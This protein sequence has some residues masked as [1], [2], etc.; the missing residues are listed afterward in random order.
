MKNP[1]LSPAEIHA[2]IAQLQQRINDLAAQLPDTS[3]V[4][5]PHTQHNHLGEQR[6]QILLDTASIA[7]VVVDNYG[8]IL[9]ANQKASEIF[10]YTSDE[11]VNAPVSI[12]L[13]QHLRETHEEH[14]NR[15]F[16]HPRPRPM[17]QGMDL[18]AQRQNGTLFPIEVSL[19]AIQS[20]QGMQGVA[21][22]VDISER[23]RAEQQQLDLLAEQERVDALQ[24]FVVDVAHDLK[25]PMAAVM[26]RIHI[27][28]KLL[29]E[30]VA[31]HT[32]K[33][34]GHVDRLNHLV[35]TMLLMTQL[36]MIVQLELQTFDVNQLVHHAVDSSQA[37]LQNKHH[38]LTY[39][40][41]SSLPTI[42]V[43]LQHLMTAI[44]NI[45]TN[46][47]IFTPE[48]GQI[49]ITTG[50]TEH[51]II[52]AVQDNGMGIAET[53]LPHIF[54]RFYRA[55]RSRSMDESINGLGLAIAKRIVDLHH[56]EIV[57]ESEVGKGSTFR[58]LLPVA[59]Q[60]QPNDDT[61]L[62]HEIQRS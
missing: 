59:T 39:N 44:K 26:T 47:V 30:A 24:N 7:I 27:M 52:V 1:K 43:H 61:L 21:F 54:K 34:A 58:L 6:F 38:H 18:M 46:A 2:E 11:L 23:K 19:S 25:T 55:D 32:E 56:G 4:S 10:G 49:T 57:V 28:D 60:N 13:P 22:I 5:I 20:E 3:A 31:H 16:A 15:F 12:L 45:L 53:D 41:D 9:I 33:L 35:D 51:G 62:L 48:G 40:L 29:G 50:T 36:D 37:Q 8:K 42:K 14:L 17:G